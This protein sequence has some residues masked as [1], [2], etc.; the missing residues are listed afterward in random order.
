MPMIEYVRGNN[1]VI[2][3]KK[4]LFWLPYII[5]MAEL[6]LYNSVYGTL[7]SL[8]MFFACA[9]NLSYAMIFMKLI[10]DFLCGEYRKK[11]LV[12]ILFGTIFLAAMTLSTGNKAMLIYWAFIVAAHDA[13]LEKIVKAA[14][15][16]HFICM[17]FVTASSVM[18]IIEDRIY[19]GGGERLRNSLGYQYTT[20]S[21]NYY[22][23]MIL[24]YIYVKKEKISWESIGALELCNIL[25]FKLTDT[26]STFLLGSL[27]LAVAL[28][29]KIFKGARKNNIIYKAGTVMTVPALSALTIY[30][31][32]FYNEQKPWMVHLN[33]ILSGR[34]ALG[35]KA[36]KAYGLHLWGKPITWV[37]GTNKYIEGLGEY[38]Y[39]DSS[40]IQIL[41]NFG[42]IFFVLICLLLMALSWKTIKMN[43]VYL[44]LAL[45]MI[46][47]HSA[48]DP[49][50][51]WMA[52]NPFIM[53][54]SYMRKESSEIKPQS[55]LYQKGENSRTALE[56]Q[57]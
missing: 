55:P 48:A 31:S 23:H 53:C 41:L 10:L 20:D 33:S 35:Y 39:V 16:I 27:A 2:E 11:E 1:L 36:F 46:A 3:K 9:R 56:N 30:L 43:D 29:W 26:K 57:P 54:Y 40:Y 52:F 42:I 37:G 13:E 15:I 24:M 32:F 14:L 18:G 5:Y 7:D 6:L 45:V 4:C 38:N 34:L 47:I 49:Q 22:F 12:F 21:S 25:L 19:D 17:V 44:M 51:L 50:L 28:I 8:Q